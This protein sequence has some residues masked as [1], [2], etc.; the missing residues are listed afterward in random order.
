[1]RSGA[2]VLCLGFL[3]LVGCGSSGASAD[4]AADATGLDVLPDATPD[5]P[6]AA[7]PG[8]DLPAPADAREAVDAAPEKHEDA[9]PDLPA[10]ISPE[11]VAP[12]DVCA[13][14]G[15]PVRPFVDAEDD[16]TLYATAADFTVETTDG[17]WNLKERW[18]GCET[19]LFIQDEPRQDST[20]A[21]PKALW[22]RDV[23]ALLKAL[24]ANTQVF[25]VPTS[26]DVGEV[27]AALALVQGQVQTF[28]DQQPPADR[29]RWLDRVHF[30]TQTARA[31]PGWLGQHFTKP[32]W[33][34]GIDRFQRVRYIGS[35]GDPNRY[36][37]GLGWFE[38]NLAMAANEAT[39]YE[40]EATR[41]A[42]LDAE[43]ATV[44]PV[45]ANEVLEDP[46]WAGV[47][48]TKDIVLPDAAAMAG[49]DSLELDLTLNCVGAGELGEC[50]AW[51]YD[52]NLYLCDRDDPTKCD[53]DLAHWITTYHREGR[54]VHDLSGLLPLLEGGGARR[55]QFYTQQKYEVTLGLR[56]LNRGKAARPFETHFLWGT[57]DFGPTYNEGFQPRSIL[58]PAEATKVELMSVITG[59]GGVSPGNCAEFCKT[60]HTFTVNG[61]DHV[62]EH[63][64]AGTGVQCMQD[65][66]KGTVPNQYGTWWYGRNGWCPGREVAPVMLDV[67]AEVTPGQEAALAYQGLYNGQ[68]YPSGGAVIR[69]TSW[70]VFS[71]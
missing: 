20:T 13:A 50:P 25:F 34:V 58:V 21:W 14:T 1:M 41:Q 24:P 43:G 42:A 62:L 30:V 47:R 2:L 33:G 32:A 44:V 64:E 65:V 31:I 15:Q 67:T 37:V 16:P 45:F 23:D 28:V 6:D 35:Y 69:M 22:S 66:S 70:L 40:F 71:R 17:P 27:N 39:Y 49:F 29:D 5:A 68:P 52:V 54:W 19:Y 60:T 4:V 56:L 8:P 9:P 12:Y 61:H 59:H 57:A 11:A 7:D 10:D 38:P 55:L 53:T 26:A 18:T 36:H 48:G 63:P 51:D 46:G 3:V